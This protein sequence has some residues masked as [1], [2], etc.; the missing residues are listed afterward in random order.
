MEMTHRLFKAGNRGRSVNLSPPGALPVHMPF[1]SEKSSTATSA[2]YESSPIAP[3]TMIYINDVTRINFKN[4]HYFD[5]YTNIW[6][7][8]Q[9]K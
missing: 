4:D 6:N 5:C 3:S 8:L 9:H 1:P 2:E 7:I